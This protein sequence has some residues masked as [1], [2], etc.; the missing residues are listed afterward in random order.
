LGE[1]QIVSNY[2][3]LYGLGDDIGIEEVRRHSALEGA[4]TD[5]LLHSSRE[6]RWQEFADC[7]GRLYAELP[8]LNKLNEPTD[9]K[10][11]EAWGRL[12]GGHSKVFEVGSGRGRLIQY[13]AGLGNECHATEITPE[14]GEKFVDPATGV[15][16][17]QTD[18]VNLSRFTTENT[19][20]YVISDQ[21]FEHLHP[22]DH[23]IHLSEACK[24][25]K[26]RGQYI[27]RTP[28]PSNGPHDL[29][30]VFGVEEPVF[31]HLWEPTYDYLSGMMKK[32]GFS[33][34]AAVF[35]S[36]SL[37]ICMIS[38]GFLKYQ[39]LADRLEA[40]TTSSREQKKQFRERFGKLLVRSFT[41]VVGQR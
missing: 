1:A 6:T 5:R 3:R 36:G 4:L 25:L 13:L 15:I 34:V 37:G 31:M 27:L 24:I 26:P 11:M 23:L 33:R 8:W 30:Q 32:A 16:W 40:A 2:R 21:V 22:N 28:H 19:F 17:E 41:W 10:S 9:T 38:S 14:R 7:Y 29:S 18:G 12:I 39:V 35:E 20:D